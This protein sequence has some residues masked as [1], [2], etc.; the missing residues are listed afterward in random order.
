MFTAVYTDFP[1]ML[2][3]TSPVAALSTVAVSVTL[4]SVAF[5]ST[6]TVVFF[7]SVFCSI[8]VNETSVVALLK[9][10]SPK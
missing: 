2:N 5:T 3:S 10:S 7:S 4:F 1:F 9:L 6:S 8:T